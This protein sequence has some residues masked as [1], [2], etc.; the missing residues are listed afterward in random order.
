MR[1]ATLVLLATLSVAPQIAWAAGPAGTS[2]PMQAEPSL[3]GLKDA[4]AVTIM[5]LPSLYESDAAV[6]LGEL[7][8][9]ACTF[10]SAPGA[11]AEVREVAG[12]V[13]Q[14][15]Y[16]GRPGAVS[17]PE[18]NSLGL[19]FFKGTQVLATLYFVDLDAAVSGGRRYSVRDGLRA[20]L[21]AAAFGPGF[22]FVKGWPT[23]PED[24]Y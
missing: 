18:Q 7:D 10:K 21:R 8:K 2:A 19:R 15:L 9:E 12:L 6:Q 23:C 20:K 17:T 3:E 14:G 13:S 1:V 24:K 5:F 11:L 4:D 22:V 16:G